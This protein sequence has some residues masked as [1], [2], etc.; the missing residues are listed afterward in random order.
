VVQDFL[1]LAFG[2]SYGSGEGNPDLPI[3]GFRFT[4]AERAYEDLQDAIDRLADVQLDYDRTV[5][6]TDLVLTR[7]S[8]YNAALGDVERF[9][10]PLSG[11]AD[12]DRC[13]D[14]GLRAGDAGIQLTQALT[15]L[16]LQALFDTLDAIQ[17]E[18]AELVA[19]A[20]AALTLARNAMSDA[21]NALD[22]AE[23]ALTADWQDARCHRSA[24]SRPGARGQAA[25]GSGSAHLRHARAS[26]LLGRRHPRGRHRPVQGCRA[27]VQP[28]GA[29]DMPTHFVR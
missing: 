6:A 8:A 12:P 13:I 28:S 15:A 24:I 17:T 11:E 3:P 2:D 26:R 21:R 9:C 5:D 14:A 22:N 19:A 23:A 20:D 29:P 7:L 18:M 27:A 4:N 16:G 10:N 1:V 25:G